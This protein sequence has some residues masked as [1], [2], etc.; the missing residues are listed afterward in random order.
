M[1][2]FAISDNGQIDDQSIE[3]SDASLLLPD[4]NDSP[5]SVTRPLDKQQNYP[6][7]YLLGIV[8]ASALGSFLW[9]YHTSVI[10]GAML[11]VDDHF[12]LTV[13]WHEVVVS[14]AIAGAAMG[15]ITAG[16]LSDRLGRWKVM[17]ASAVLFGLGSAILGL[18]FFKGFLVVGRAV[19][20]LASGEYLLS[21]DI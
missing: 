6:K 4:D 13:L 20:G 15:V 14:V 16:M 10:A 19:V 11:F 8:V 5:L 12:N 7:R 3:S 9:G 17:M 2:S 1:E 21:R 18:S